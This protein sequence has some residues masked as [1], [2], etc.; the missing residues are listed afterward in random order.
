M[1]TIWQWFV[2]NWKTNTVALVS[3]VY[4]ATQFT[5]AVQAWENHQT[6]NWRAAIVSL[7]V[8]FG[9]FAAKD[10]SNVPTA[11]EVQAATT[12]AAGGGGK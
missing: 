1:G 6:P 3:I 5:A 11:T 9:M 4:S 7:I 12:K 10:A 2:K 8:A